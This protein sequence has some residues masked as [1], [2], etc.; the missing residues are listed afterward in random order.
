MR[1][2]AELFSLGLRHHLRGH[3]QEAERILRELLRTAPRHAGALHILGMIAYQSGRFAVAVSCFQ[4]AV[5]ADASRALFHSSLG[6]AYQAIGR[7]AEARICHERARALNPRDVLVLNNLGIT[8]A[9]QGEQ[10]QAEALFR[11]ALALS[12]GDPEVL[13]NLSA[14]LRSMGKPEAAIP[15]LRQALQARP[16]LGEIHYNLGNA[17]A[18]LGR[19]EEALVCY[20]Q[21]ARCASGSALGYQCLG[22]MLQAQGK[23]DEAIVAYRQA[24]R[25]QPDS[26]EACS[27]LGHAL[28]IRNQTAEA[29]ACCQQ[30]ARL[31]PHSADA[32]NGL[33]NVYYAQ[34]CLDQAVFCYRSALHRQPELPS[35]RYN[36]GVALQAQGKLAE[37]H[38]CYREVL[39]VK[40]DDPVAHSTYA[41]SLIY[42]PSV[43]GRR[44]LAE[45][46]QW[47]ATHT[48]TLT[49][50]PPPNDRADPERRLRVGYVSPDLRAHPMAYFLAP[51]LAAHD[52]VQVET[53]CYAEVPA[54]DGMTAHLR[55]LAGRWRETF[56][57]SDRQLAELIR[58]DG[59]DILVDLAGHTAGNRLLVF[60]RKP[61]PVQVSYLGYPCTTGLTAIDYRLGDAVTDPPD[62]PACYAEALV[63]LEGV[64]CCYAPPRNTSPVSPLPAPTRGGITF[65]SLHKLEKLNGAV[66]DLWCR[67]LRALPCA[68]ILLSR[69]TL[70]GRNGERVLS[71]FQERGIARDRVVLHHAEPVD[72][73][74]LRIY[75]A[76]DIALDPFPWNGHTTACEA[77][78]MGVPVVALRGQRHSGRMVVSVLN[79]VGLP[80]LTADSAEEYCRIAVGLATDLPRLSRLRAELRTRMGQSPLCDAGAFTRRLEAAYRGMWRAWCRSVR[81]GEPPAER[82]SA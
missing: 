60:A 67:I 72:L 12:P 63:R 43:D 20:G 54:P 30:A 35:A 6:A 9:A 11:E 37:A 42:D 76:I 26:F 55:V 77:L 41:G 57:L 70:H 44:L 45:H 80:E 5:E 61:A 25:V 65:G 23:L 59:I 38:A 48:A 4:G 2:T 7:L 56:G 66:L 58:Q 79:A 36:L 62:Q 17:L 46:Q 78:W 73:H 29:L 68:R 21:A 74:H 53:T 19:Q 13:C 49:K 28:L 31:R 24:L 50:Q 1:D 39:R 16:N 82:L 14:L 18:D 3:S 69:N 40:P 10:E 8:L 52:P 22:R 51:I 64:F 34:G 81:P 33:G 47:A 32:F 15:P 75:D 27:S 71:E